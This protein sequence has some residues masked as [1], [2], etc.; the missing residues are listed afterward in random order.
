MRGFAFVLVLMTATAAQAQP[1]PTAKLTSLLDGD[2]LIPLKIEAPLRQLFESGGDDETVTVPATVTAGNAVWHDVAL[3]VRGH[4]SRRETECTFPKLKLKLKGAGSL[5]IGTHCGESADGQLTQKY[6]R[7]ANERSPLREVVAYR[8]LHAAAVPALRARAARITYVDTG[9]GGAPL[10]RNA[11]V[12]EDD[13]DAMAR[14]GGTRELTLETFGDVSSRHASGDAGL[15]AFGEALIGNFDWCLKFTADDAYRCDASKP[16]WNLLAFERGAGATL[17]MKDFDLAG[18][19]VG[20]HPWFDTVWNRAFVASKSPVDIEVLSQV[21]R[22]RSLFPRDALDELRRHFLERRDA[23]LSAIQGA[24][25]DAEGRRLALGY[26]N[27]FFAAIG[28]DQ[29]FYRPVVA[30]PDVQ[31]YLDPQRTKEACGPKD[32]I[33]PGTPVNEVQ[34]SG[35]MSQVVILDVMWRWGSKNECNNVQNGPVWI[36]TGSITSD[37]PSRKIQ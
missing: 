6:G 32:A 22:T 14:A 28:D 17:M 12:L 18:V 2:S 23:V 36:V 24:E 30:R 27:A 21:Q 35:S 29:A 15:V 33:R 3:S 8:M 26:A 5:K 19:V 1:P 20:R 13:D 25:V 9:T 11:L 10:T 4:T 16:V 34:R 31:V 7:L 37:Y